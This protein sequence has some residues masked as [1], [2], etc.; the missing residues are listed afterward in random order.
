MRIDGELAE[1]SPDRDSAL[2]L[3]V[4]D[5]V[6][7]GHQHLI[8]ATVKEARKSGRL[9]L[10]ATFRNHPGSV[11]RPDFRPSY[12]TGLDDR[13]S[14][15][16]ALGVDR[17]IP[18]TFDLE[19]SELGARDFVALLQRRLRMQA[20]VVGPDFALGRN[21]EGDVPTLTSLSNDMGFSLVVSDLLEDDGRPVRSTV[22]RQALAEGDL[23]LVQTL[24]G[25][26]FALEGAVERGAG[27]GK[28]LGFPTANLRIAPDRALPGDGIYATWAL[29]GERRHMA[30]T[31]IGAR[32]TFG[33]TDR[34][35]EAFLLDFDG[36][37]YGSEVRLEFVQ[38]LRDDVKYDSVEALKDQIGRDVDETRRILGAV[39]RV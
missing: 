2:T 35:V 38:R 31:S 19:L 7:R 32:P 24:L 22:V 10:V 15:M 13:I 21:R 30:A 33:E 39:S 34:T 4:F 25:R 12:I 20:L 27:R 17:V 26:H 36:D 11:L 5:G 29:V 28:V 18:I 8:R 3:G 23:A 9:A 14:L 1:A 16:G 37:L 6:H